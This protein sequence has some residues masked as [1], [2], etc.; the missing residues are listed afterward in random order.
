M[1]PVRSSASP[2]RKPP[3]TSSASPDPK[4]LARLALWQSFSEVQQAELETTAF[5]NAD[6]FI[7]AGWQRAEET[8]SDAVA[9]GYRQAILDRELDRVAADRKQQLQNA[10]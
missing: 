9:A 3:K 7:L 2:A 1:S 8:G 10:S 4:R 5:A 6:P